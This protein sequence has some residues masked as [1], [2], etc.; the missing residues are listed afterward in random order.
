MA[1]NPTGTKILFWT[2]EE[3]VSLIWTI[4][5]ILFIRGFIVE[6]FKIPS[7]SMVPTLLVGDH[8]FVA[9]TAYDIGLPFTNIPVI[10]VADPQ[11]GDVIVFEYPNYEK[12][13]ENTKDGAYYIKRLIGVPGDRIEIKGGVP[14]INGNQ[15]AQASIPFEKDNAELPGFEKIYASHDVLKE[16]IPGMPHDHWVQRKPETL[17]RVPEDIANWQFK[18]GKPCVDPGELV[19]LEFWARQKAGAMLNE[20]CPFTVP[21][22]Y[23]FAMGDNR[24]NSA[25]SREWGFV[26]RKLLKGRALFIWMSADVGDRGST[27]VIPVPFRDKFRWSRFGLAIK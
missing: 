17:E 19:F 1:K 7:E 25:D 16:S 14:I 2:K 8:L 15:V 12:S 3:W 11:R 23:Y 20:V 4:L 24:D 6:P 5:L 22:D 9:K 27:F 26:S 18:T 21:P 13:N 10:R